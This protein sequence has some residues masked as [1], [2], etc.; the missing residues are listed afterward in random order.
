MRVT[1]SRATVHRT[2]PDPK[3]QGLQVEVLKDEVRDDVEHFEPYGLT[4]HPK[5]ADG[6]QGPEAIV[7]ELG[8]A[9]HTVAVVVGDRRYRLTGLDEGEVALYDDLGQVVHLARDHIAIEA[10]AGNSVEVYGPDSINLHSDDVLLGNSADAAL[11]KWPALKTFMDQLLL[12]LAAAT[13]SGVPGTTLAW[14]TALPTTPPDAT[15]GTEKV[16]AK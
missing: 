15:G 1:A 9:D 6:S 4:S 14:P 16:T 8:S 3:M 12:A 11:A 7:I 2:D 13:H 5:E 10:A